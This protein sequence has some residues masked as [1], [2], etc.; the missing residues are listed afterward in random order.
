MNLKAPKTQSIVAFINCLV[1]NVGPMVIWWY[2]DMVSGLL[3]MGGCDWSMP[4][5]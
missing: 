1:L 5:K 2:G 4:I 3:P